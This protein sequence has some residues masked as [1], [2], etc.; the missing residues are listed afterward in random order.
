MAEEPVDFRTAFKGTFTG[1]LRWPQ[2]DA[3]WERIRSDA[4]GGW[5][6]YAVG[7]APPVEC[8]SAQELRR[9][10]DSIDELLRR[11]HDEDY[12]GIVYVDDPGAPSFV[13]IFDPNN[14]GVSC[15][16]SDN[17]PLPGWILSKLPPVDLQAPMPLPGNRRRWWQR[18]FAS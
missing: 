3:L 17:P 10:I 2:L 1:I 14:L 12:C 7:E 5:Y 15:G 16:Y 9:F 11:E 13:K 8:V 18:L 4:N 6:L